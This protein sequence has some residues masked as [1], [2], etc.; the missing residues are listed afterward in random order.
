MEAIRNLTDAKVGDEYMVNS[1]TWV[2]SWLI[3][4]VS[5]V[6]PTRVEVKSQ[7]SKM[8]WVFHKD[9]ARE[10]G[11]SQYYRK[12]LYAIDNS[13]L[14]KQKIE[15]MRNHIN[16]VIYYKRTQTVDSKPRQ[17]KQTAAIRGRYIIAQ[18]RPTI[19]SCRTS[20]GAIRPLGNYRCA[21][22]TSSFH[23]CTK[24]ARSNA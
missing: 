2:N 21:G 1:E 8:S 3:V 15:T 14:Q 9:D 24:I 22:S 4:N 7:N 20:K 17:Y 19:V 23:A 18:L 5:R 13:V 10:V 11:G 12:S 16:H 6:M